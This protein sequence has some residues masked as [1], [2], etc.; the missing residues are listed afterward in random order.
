MPRLIACSTYPGIRALVKEF[1]CRR[2]HFDD[3]VCAKVIWLSRKAK[4]CVTKTSQS[5]PLF[6]YIL[7]ISLT[8]WMLII[9]LPEL[10]FRWLYILPQLSHLDFSGFTDPNTFSSLSNMGLTVSLDLDLLI[11][12]SE[13][14][15]LLVPYSPVRI[16]A[17]VHYIVV[18]ECRSV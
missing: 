17:S 2:V 9:T 10:S 13:S 6:I 7:Q 14:L 5:S 15:G 18:S 4:S 1:V 12:F 16:S 8:Q 3:F 11:M